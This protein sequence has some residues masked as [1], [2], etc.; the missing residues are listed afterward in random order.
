MNKVPLFES[1][2]SIAKNIENKNVSP[3]E[4]TK[5][6]LARLHR[7]G[8]E[9]NS[10]VTVTEKL[11]LDQAALAEKEIM[12]GNYKGLLHGIPFGAKD[13]LATKYGIPTTWGAEPF[14]NQI[15]RIKIF[16]KI[17]KITN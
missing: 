14:R 13:L 4:I 5:Y 2:R 17:E 11:A 3:I 1:L 16:V 9:Y 10:V 6:Y 7:L 15:R 8:P 12:D